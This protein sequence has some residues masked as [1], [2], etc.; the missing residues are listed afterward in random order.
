MSEWGTCDTYVEGHESQNFHFCL[1]DVNW[2][3]NPAEEVVACSACYSQ[4]YNK[5]HPPW[6]SNFGNCDTYGI[7]SSFL[8]DIGASPEY[9]LDTAADQ[10]S[11][12][13]GVEA[14]GSIE[15]G[16]RSPACEVTNNRLPLT[17]TNNLFY[18]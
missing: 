2:A 3:T 6:T 14:D 16:T 5:C 12:W 1:F 13:F 15:V 10:A 11:G 18:L 4:C 7:G 17:H 9:C 8:N